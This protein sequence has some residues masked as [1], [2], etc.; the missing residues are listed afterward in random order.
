MNRIIIA[1]LIMAFV[2]YLSRVLPIA[3]FQK[4]ITSKIFKS[5]LYYVPFA[6]LGA[7]T[8][9]DILFST[10]SICSAFIG[11]MVALILA[12]FEQGLVKVAICSVLAVY[13]FNLLLAY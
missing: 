2:T 7:M 6:V 1:V 5:F 8:F 11:T 12:Y 10:S 4:R 13:L 9:P 3:F